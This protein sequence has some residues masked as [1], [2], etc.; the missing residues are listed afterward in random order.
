MQILDTVPH[1]IL[2]QGENLCTQA[3]KK[4][5]SQSMVAGVSQDHQSSSLS[6]SPPISPVW[7]S[8]SGM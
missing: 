5:I 8:H 2:M 7:A 3:T 4:R 6:G 1:T